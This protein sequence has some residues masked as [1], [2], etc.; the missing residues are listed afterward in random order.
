MDTK[1]FEYDL[2][3]LRK[4][5]TDLEKQMIQFDEIIPFERQTTAKIFSPRLLNM[6]ISCG[7]QIEAITELI[8]VR[9]NIELPKKKNIPELIQKMNSKGVLS[10]L[11]ISTLAH[12][13]LFTPFTRDL[14]WWQT[15]NDLKHE[16]AQKQSK[17]TYTVVMDA[18][19]ALAALHRLAEVIKVLGESENIQ[20]ILQRDYWNP[21]FNHEVRFGRKTGPDFLPGPWKSLIFKIS[22][23]FVYTGGY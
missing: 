18:L 15:Y 4:L 13:I 20:Y 23:Y 9:C 21:T 17:T 7:P 8:C 19:A 2:N 5:H 3:N 22:N 1:S 12:G 16:L 14:E 11:E 6:M 10:N